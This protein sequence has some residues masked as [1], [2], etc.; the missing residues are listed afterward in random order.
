MCLLE[1]NLLGVLVV[2]VGAIIGSFLSV[3]IYRIPLGRRELYNSSGDIIEPSP[4]SAEDASRSATGEQSGVKNPTLLSP[5]RS[6]CPSCGKQLLWWHNIPIISWIILRGKCG[7]CGTGV[8]VRYPLVELM[9]ALFA[10]LSY[11]LY[12]PTLTGLLVFMFSATMIV[13]SFIDY[14]YYIIPNSISLPG[15][16][17]GVVIATVN[18]FTGVFSYPVVPGLLSAFLGLL[19]GAGF[20]LFVSEVYFR[21]RKKDGLGMGDVKLLA[22]TGVLFGPQAAIYTIFIGSL[23][24]AVIGVTLLLIFKKR[25][26]QHL[27]F[28]PYLAAATLLYLFGYEELIADIG[29][30][31]GKLML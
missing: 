23:L 17:I 22:M 4:P 29:M 9:S 15:F 1:C 18:E 19:S 14:D 26:T 6:F 27:P 13:I 25:L 5:S 10:F 12:G 31:I 7:F 3:C 2:V 21:L 24:G 28:G 20:L 8:S 30:L 11:S 16:A